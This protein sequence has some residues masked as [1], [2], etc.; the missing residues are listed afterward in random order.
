[1]DPQVHV[2]T[3]TP[4]PVRLSEKGST[5]AE[6]GGTRTHYLESGACAVGSSWLS[7]YMDLVG[8]GYV[9]S[10]RMVSASYSHLL[11]IISPHETRSGPSRKRD[12]DQFFLNTLESEVFI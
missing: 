1:M 5:V 3:T 9:L 2:V 10:S 12:K 4:G 6:R 11:P 7:V 8:S